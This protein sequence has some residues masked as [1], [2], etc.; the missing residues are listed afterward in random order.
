MH[1]TAGFPWRHLR[2]LNAM[3]RDQQDLRGGRDRCL[4]QKRAPQRGELVGFLPELQIQSSARASISISEHRR[5][6]TAS[7]C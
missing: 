5:F 6:E 4:R 1:Q 3:D 7:C 2:R